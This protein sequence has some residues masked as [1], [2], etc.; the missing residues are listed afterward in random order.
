MH[1]DVD[2]IRNSLF[3][4]LWQNASHC[5]NNSKEDKKKRKVKLQGWSTEHGRKN[6]Q[7]E[8]QV[9]QIAQSL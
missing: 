2:Q 6:I 7:E 3:E 4:V 9:E 1:T 5:P 8:W